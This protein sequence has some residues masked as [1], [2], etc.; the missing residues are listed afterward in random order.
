MSPSPASTK[1]GLEFPTV[2]LVPGIVRDNYQK[3]KAKNNGVPDIFFQQLPLHT[4]LYMCTCVHAHTYMCAHMHKHSLSG[5][6]ISKVN[7]Y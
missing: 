2:S 5:F 4:G 1:C 6:T 7:T 3:N